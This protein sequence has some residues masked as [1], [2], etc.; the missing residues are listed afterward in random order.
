[1]F[2]VELF[3]CEYF[4]GKRFE[5]EEGHLILLFDYVN[6]PPNVLLPTL[7][8]LARRDSNKYSDQNLGVRGYNNKGNA[9]QYKIPKNN[10][11]LKGY[12]Q[13]ARLHVH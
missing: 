8:T 11:V 3:F 1:V 4:C 6:Y 12:Q 13:T 7:L 10:Q 5:F 2:F 9:E